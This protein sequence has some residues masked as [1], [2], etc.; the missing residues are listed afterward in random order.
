MVE[1]ASQDDIKGLQY[2][3]DDLKKTV[4]ASHARSAQIEKRY[5]QAEANGLRPA[6]SPDTTTIVDGSGSS[7]GAMP[8]YG[9]IGVGATDVPS[10]SSTRPGKP[11]VSDAAADSGFANPAGNTSTAGVESYHVPGTQIRAPEGGADAASVSAQETLRNAMANP[12][13]TDPNNPV[14]DP[15]SQTPV[16][17]K[18]SKR[19][20]VK[21][22]G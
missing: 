20:R 17:Q 9:N 22:K 10:T 19:Q 16:E 13:P 8:G 3:I 18:R 14:N 11:R 7:R 12:D 21:N 2:Q 5:N 6:A 4:Q 1:V 15:L